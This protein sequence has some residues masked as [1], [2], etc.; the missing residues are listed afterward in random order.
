MLASKIQLEAEGIDAAA[1]DVFA[2][3]LAE[4]CGEVVWICAARGVFGLADN[5]DGDHIERV[6]QGDVGPIVDRVAVA[7]AE[8]AELA[9]A[10]DADQVWSAERIAAPDAEFGVALAAS[11][12]SEGERGEEERSGRNASPEKCKSD[13]FRQRDL[14]GRGVWR[15]PWEISIR[16]ARLRQCLLKALADSTLAAPAN[17]ARANPLQ[18][19]ERRDPQLKL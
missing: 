5:F 14:I 2:A 12:R 16:L 11:G 6:F 13:C 7:E 15:P 10:G 1:V 9:I 17:P 4:T 19:K 18:E 3:G 8:L